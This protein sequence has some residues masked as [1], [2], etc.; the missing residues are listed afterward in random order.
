MV[1]HYCF[2]ARLFQQPDISA[3]FYHDGKTLSLTWWKEIAS[4]E[5]LFVQRLQTDHVHYLFHV[6]T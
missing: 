6:Q 4:P 5:E 2:T 1:H 3:Q